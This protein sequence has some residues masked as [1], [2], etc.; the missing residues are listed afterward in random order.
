MIIGIF[1][2][3]VYYDYII[4]IAIL[5]I[6]LC[7]IIKNYYIL[8]I[9]LGICFGI[10]RSYLLFYFTISYLPK[11][12]YGKYCYLEGYIISGSNQTY[13]IKVAKIT[14]NF[15]INH[16]FANKSYVF[17]KIDRILE[18]NQFIAVQ[19]TLYPPITGF[20]KTTRIQKI[21]NSI[22]GFGKVNRIIFIKQ[23]YPKYTEYIIGKC[24]EK[25]K[26]FIRASILG[27]T[28][29]ISKE[30]KIKMD[31]AG[32]GYLLAISG[33]HFSIVAGIFYLIGRYLFVFAPTYLPMQ[34]FGMIFSALAS[35]GYFMLTNPTYS[36]IRSLLMNIG[37]IGLMLSIRKNSIIFLTLSMILTLT[38][39]PYGI[40]DLSFQLSYI[41]VYT[42]LLFRGYFNGI[43]FTTLT[44][45]PFILYNIGY[46]NVQSIISSIICGSFFTFI[47][48]PLIFIGFIIQYPPYIICCIDYSIYLFE[49]LVD[50]TTIL[51]YEIEARI[52]S[53]MLCACIINFITLVLV[54]NYGMF[55]V[56]SILCILAPQKHRSYIVI[57]KCQKEILFIKNN[58]M[59][60][61]NP[62]SF[63]TQDACQ[64]FAIK[65]IYEIPEYM[66]RKNG[67]IFDNIF[68]KT[69]NNK[70]IMAE[71]SNHSIIARNI[72]IMREEGIGVIDTEIHKMHII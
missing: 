66:K 15:G 9:L 61:A 51:P 68:I 23:S 28:H 6:I 19:T 36:V 33:I 13:K 45:M 16:D 5:N 72:D 53:A 26:S 31:K 55:A 40:F 4:Y 30:F 65:K 71:L 11:I 12:T 69:I 41:S 42:L 3:F 63:F 24:P 56:I 34:Y 25:A 32:L 43:I 60:A 67:F 27:D 47:M 70:F 37:Y 2:S 22:I 1:V 20:H 8:S 50:L 64:Y 21:C 35:I 57:S 38:V 18:I 17:L 62:D 46:I 44:T 58:Y 7:F 39:Y 54:R 49:Y 10:V 14:D 29:L 48:L 59:F 52:S